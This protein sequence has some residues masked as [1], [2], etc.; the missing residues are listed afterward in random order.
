[1]QIHEYM[2]QAISHPSSAQLQFTVGEAVHFKHDWLEY[3]EYRLAP[4]QEYY[5]HSLFDADTG[6][7]QFQLKHST[8]V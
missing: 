7:P 4:L 5:S 3:F 1:M 8:L 2:N 6:I